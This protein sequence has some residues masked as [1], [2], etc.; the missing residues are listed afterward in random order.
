MRLLELDSPAVTLPG[1]V[2]PVLCHLKISYGALLVGLGKESVTTET[3]Y[4]QT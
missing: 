1:S 4:T 2:P 3:V